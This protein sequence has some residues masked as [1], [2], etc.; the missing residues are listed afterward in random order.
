MAR[1]HIPI[2]NLARSCASICHKTTSPRGHPSG[3]LPALFLPW[4]A[5]I[6]F[7]NVERVETF[8][9]I[10]NSQQGI[11]FDSTV[12]LDT[13]NHNINSWGKKSPLNIIFLHVWFFILPRWP[14]LKITLL[15]V[16]SYY[17]QPSMYCH[18]KETGKG[19]TPLR[20]NIRGIPLSANICKLRI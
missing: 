17:W 15:L 6:C 5:S 16:R 19:Q 2:C 3:F 8:M 7:L 11:F 4:L 12:L 10:G 14:K 9:W 18:G 1:H 20:N 13:G